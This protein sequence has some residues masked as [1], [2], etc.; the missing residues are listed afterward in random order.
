MS[1]A[2]RPSRGDMSVVVSMLRAVN[3]GRHNRI[4][5][6]ALRALYESLGLP[7]ARTYV[8]SGNVIFRTAARDLALLSGRI[9]D[10]FEQSF[11]FHSHVIVRTSSELRDV[12]AKNPF[13]TRGGID[14]SKLVVMFLARHPD[15]LARD[16]I[17]AIKADPEE[18][19]IEGRELYIYF[20]HGM[21]RPKLSAA[22]I[23]RTLQTPGTVRNWNTVTRLLEMAE[24][25][26]SSR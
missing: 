24:N 26:E 23:E 22:L 3:V 8:Q 21:A 25:L 12:I 17:L 14:P 9:E 20:P 18:F 5:M 16:K 19:R 15:P 13:A 6:E 11:G 2:K 1:H 7:D 10:G 4:K